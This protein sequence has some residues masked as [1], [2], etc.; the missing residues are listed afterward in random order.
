MDSTRLTM[1]GS[2]PIAIGAHHERPDA[3]NKDL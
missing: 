2:I 3:M 1:S